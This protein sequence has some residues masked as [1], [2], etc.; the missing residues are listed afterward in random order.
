MIVACV[1]VAAAMGSAVAEAQNSYT[2]VEVR[3]LNKA[4]SKVVATVCNNPVLAPA[5]Y[6]CAAETVAPYSVTTVTLPVD[7]AEGEN[8]RIEVK[9]RNRPAKVLKI[10]RSDVLKLMQKSGFTSGVHPAV[11]AVVDKYGNV[12]FG[13]VYLKKDV[14]P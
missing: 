11:S 3:V 4:A 6:E 7:S 12:S 9:V 10:K 13:R 1:A 2:S 8:Y 5:L 14:A